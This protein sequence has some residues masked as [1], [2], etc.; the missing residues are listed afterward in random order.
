[1]HSKTAIDIEKELRSTLRFLQRQG[2]QE[3]Q[4]VS[5][6]VPEDTLE[7]SEFSQAEFEAVAVSRRLLE[8]EAYKPSRCFLNFIPES[9]KQA[10]LAY[11]LP[12]LA[13]KFLIPIAALLLILWA[14]VQI[15]SFFQDYEFKWLN[16]KFEKTSKKTS[17]NFAAQVHLSKLFISYVIAGNNN[18]SSTMNNVNR[19]LKGRAQVLGVSWS[20]TAHGTELRLKFPSLVK[21]KNQDFKKYI[22]QNGER[23]LGDVNI[24]WDEQASET[25]LLVQQQKDRMVGK[26]GN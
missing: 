5:V 10:N 14:T 19:L 18:P 3:G 2:Y 7:L 12:R 15:K 23:V 25:I 22:N 1:V 4:A 24:T 11:H 26:N 16:S 9:L 13:I 21:S 17:G 20:P 8:K 6:L